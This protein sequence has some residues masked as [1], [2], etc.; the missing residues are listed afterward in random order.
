MNLSPATLNAFR[1]VQAARPEVQRRHSQA[2]AFRQAHSFVE[3]MNSGK[4]G[5]ASIHICVARL[6]PQLQVKPSASIGL[7][8][9]TS[10]NRADS[11]STVKISCWHVDTILQADHCNK[12][13]MPT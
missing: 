10:K 4:E 8:L 11:T 2:Q 1:P 7:V 3:N 9:M 12:T 13:A 5:S 6:R